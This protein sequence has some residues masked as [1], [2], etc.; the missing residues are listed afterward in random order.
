MQI[1]LSKILVIKITGQSEEEDGCKK[2][3]LGNFYGMMFLWR[4]NLE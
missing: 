3:A 1:F 2:E 4:R